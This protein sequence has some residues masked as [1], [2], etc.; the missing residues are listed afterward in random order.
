MIIRKD[1]SLRIL[2]FLCLINA[3]VFSQPQNF[4]KE[5]T[6]RLYDANSV[7][8]QHFVLERKGRYTHFDKTL[9]QAQAENHPIGYQI[10]NLTGIT[11]FSGNGNENAKAA[12]MLP[13]L[14]S[15]AGSAAL[16]FGGVVF[17][18]VA[19]II[20]GYDESS[21]AKYIVLT[22][23]GVGGIA[24]SFLGFHHYRK[25]LPGNVSFKKIAPGSILGSISGMLLLRKTNGI[26]VVL[27]PSIGATLGYLF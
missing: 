24:G 23:A 5:T 15:F 8:I 25:K 21:S 10:S 26:S 19:L 11:S 20:T 12:D 16:G 27:L 14:S 13:I 2:F 4:P 6:N 1:I 22:G 18:G 9:L 7:F 17:T 3:P